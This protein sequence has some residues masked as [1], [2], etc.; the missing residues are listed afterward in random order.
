MYS[1][2]RSLIGLNEARMLIQVSVV[3][4]TTRIERQAVDAELV[5]DPEQRDPVDGL[6]ELEAGRGACGSKP[7]SRSSDRTHATRRARGPAAGRSA[8]ARRR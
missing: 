7:I 3:V 1:L 2:I 5:L 4:R 6:H 8:P